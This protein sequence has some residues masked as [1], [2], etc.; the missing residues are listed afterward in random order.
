MIQMLEVMI[1]NGATDILNAMVV[2]PKKICFVNDKKY[3]VSE[4]FLNELMRTIYLW[5]NEYGY[6][7]NIDSEEFKV[8]VTTKEGKETFH[9]K[10]VYPHNYE[11][12]KEMLGD[13]ND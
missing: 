11:H 8:I 2:F 12:L 9:G 13:I 1:H 3:K 7:S 10:G 4:D 5:K 6:D